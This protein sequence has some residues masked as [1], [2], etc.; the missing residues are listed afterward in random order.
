MARP[1]S[2]SSSSKELVLSTLK[3]SGAPLSAYKILE[4]L[5]H[6]GIK[7]APIIYRALE[8]L[9]QKGRVHA[10]KG[11][12]AFVACDCSADHQHTLSILTVCQ[13]CEQVEERHDSE[14]LKQLGA[15]QKL[16]ITLAKQAVIELPVICGECQ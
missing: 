16:G 8:A 2:L 3:E 9:T 6:S 10:V 12:N 14:L 15:V 7:S 1:T 13:Q 11:L 4:K 5:K